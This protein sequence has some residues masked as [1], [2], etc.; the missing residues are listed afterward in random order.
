MT[1]S[2]FF[3]GHIR[4]RGE[5]I[6]DRDIFEAFERAVSSHKAVRKIERN[7]RT[8]SLC[9]EYDAK[10][11]PLSKFEI[12]RE[13]LPELKKLSDAYTL[14]KAEK[15]VIIQ[16]ISELWEKLKNA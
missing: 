14:G 11:L 15:E 13:D 7:E 4:L 16:K 1:V 12:F 3:P 2:S 5:M 8:G 10:A 9:I 6:K